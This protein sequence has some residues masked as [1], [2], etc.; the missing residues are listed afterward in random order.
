MKKNI[1]LAQVAEAAGVSKTAASMALFGGAKSIKVSTATVDRI[2]EAAKKLNYI[3]NRA[4]R[5]LTSGTTHS[6]GIMFG[7]VYDLFHMELAMN[8]QQLLIKKG[9]VGIFVS[10]NNN[11]E[12]DASLRSILHQGVDGIITAHSIENIS[13]NIPV[14]LFKGKHD[15]YD[16]VELDKHDRIKRSVAYLVSLGHTNIG[17]V[18]ENQQPFIDTMSSMSLNINN[19]WLAP[20]DG[21]CDSGVEAAHH[22]MQLHNKPTAILARNDM[23]A[24]AMIAELQ[25]Q[26]IMVPHDISIIGYNNIMPSQYITPQLTTFD[27][28]LKL[29]AELLVEAMMRR[30]KNPKA[31]QFKRKIDLKLI[32]RDSC[33][34]IKSHKWV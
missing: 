12:F 1:T 9:Y 16:Y 32:V 3:P 11:K 10:W 22:F 6:I 18:T 23:V 14:V 28:Q 5:S 15:S 30:L 17:C 20:S 29:A 19:E 31:S 25:K 27:A 13:Q 2:K 4:A 33:A 8:I 7:G 24:M 34:P 26:N 21:Y